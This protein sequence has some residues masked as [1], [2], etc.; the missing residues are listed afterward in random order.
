MDEPVRRRTSCWS[1]GRV[2]CSASCRSRS[3]SASQF[4]GLE[5]KYVKLED[6]IASFERVASASSTSCPTGVLHAGGDRG[7]RGAGQENGVGL[8]H[9]SVISASARFFQGEADSV[10]APAYDGLVGIFPV[11]RPFMTL[12]VREL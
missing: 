7:R 2:A 6:T 5:G 9:V 11:T 4:T 1:G 12:W 10:V 3:S 8:M